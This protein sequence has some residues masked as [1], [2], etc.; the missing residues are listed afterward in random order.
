MTDILGDKIYWIKRRNIYGSKI[1][2][3]KIRFEEKTLLPVV[4][5]NSRNPRDGRF[6]EIIGIYHPIEN[7]RLKIDE[8]KALA[9]LNKGAQPTDTV[10]S[11]FRKLG[12]MKNTKKKTGIK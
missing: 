4:A 7:N 1:K 10:K 9:W 5:T 6:I 12:L 3:A 11:L 2:I 8:E